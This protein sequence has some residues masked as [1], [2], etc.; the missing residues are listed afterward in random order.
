ME[1]PTATRVKVYR[2]RDDYKLDV[3]LMRARGW[4]LDTIDDGR[5]QPGSGSV[6]GDL[7]SQFAGQARIV[8]R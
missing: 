4:V 1:E 5:L 3:Q 7:M 8:V 2:S 6:L